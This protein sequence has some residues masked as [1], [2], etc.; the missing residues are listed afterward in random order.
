MEKLE[1]YI[2]NGDVTSLMDLLIED[3][4]LATQPTTHQV[5]PIMLSCYYKKPQ[6]TEVL[7]NCV[8]DIS[9]FEAAAAGKF[10]R[11]AQLIIAKPTQIDDFTEDGF[12]AL[13]LA[14]YFG[15]YDVARHLVVNGA[16]VNLPS[17]NGFNVYPI[18]S[19][20]AGNYTDILKLLIEAGAE[21]NVKQ[22]AGSTPLHAA[23]QYGNLDMLIILLESGAEVNVRMEGGKLPADLAREKGYNEIAEILG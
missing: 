3:P 11:V 6:I 2:V 12:N 8:E 19:A 23:A 5:S 16:D 10:D 1:E 18:H 9:L 7:V 14:C 13:G 15:Q 4:S 21:V 20:A 22:Q 17:K